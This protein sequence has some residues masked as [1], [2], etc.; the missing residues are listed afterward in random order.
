MTENYV[1]LVHFFMQS[2]LAVGT[3]PIIDLF[4]QPPDKYVKSWIFSV[5]FKQLAICITLIQLETNVFEQSFLYVWK[6]NFRNYLGIV[7]IKAILLL[8]VMHK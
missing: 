5:V 4:L 1:K 2:A 7:E 6:G 8:E 3:C